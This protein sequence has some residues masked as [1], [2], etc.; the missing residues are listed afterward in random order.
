MEECAQYYS[1]FFPCRAVA[2]LVSRIGPLKHREFAF[3][4]SFFKRHVSVA[5]A[6]ALH[7]ELRLVRDELKTLHV[8]ALYTGVPSRLPA[9]MPHDPNSCR[10]SQPV[11]REL[12]FDVDLTD[13]DHLGLDKTDL[14]ACDAAWPMAAFAL[15]VLKR[16]L[17]DQFGYSE[18]VAVYSGRR[19]AHLWVLDQHASTLTVECRQALAC[20]LNLEFNG[21]RASCGFRTA[22]R[23]LEAY[24]LVK[25][26]F[27]EHGLKGRD[28]GGMGF[29]DEAYDVRAF[30]SALDLQ[31][32][33]LAGL[34][35]EALLLPNGKARFDYIEA[36]ISESAVGWHME[37][38]DDVIL[39]YVWPRIDVAVTSGVNHL[40]KCPFSCHATTGRIA[41]PIVEVDPFQFDPRSVPTASDLVYGSDG[42]RETFSA[43]VEKL[44]QVVSR[45]TAIHPTNLATGLSG[46]TV[47]VL[48]PDQERDIEDLAHGA[49]SA[50][51]SAS[52]RFSSASA[53]ASASTAAHSACRWCFMVDRIFVARVR[54]NALELGWKFS[55]DPE[56][57]AL[58]CTSA[59]CTPFYA[60]D[61]AEMSRSIAGSAT[62]MNRKREAY[63]DWQ[64]IGEDQGVRLC[65]EAGT[66]ESE[67]I[68][69]WASAQTRAGSFV[70]TFGSL[71]LASWTRA[72]HEDASC[73]YIAQKLQK[74]RAS[75]QPFRLA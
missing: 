51:A 50:S 36:R 47:D 12:V 69:L 60:T 27:V 15:L 63:I 66:T 18:F 54:D 70:T 62:N 17:A 22:A 31:H 53:S 48:M 38:L 57:R 71:S 74:L 16:V 35:S 56:G 4:G 23:T 30:V 33:M 41:I 67:A 10:Y 37:R 61:T 6:D 59:Q 5:S 8:G 75:A 25:P 24:S 64:T 55:Y 2:G 14:A 40:I 46:E 44:N 28:E 1:T 58:S 34:E 68:E 9:S 72:T 45:A 7:K 65:A 39:T 3:E 32:F 11:A 29:L 19:G 42:K 73:P 43:A 20:F 49:A 52:A 21:K 26:F 13:Y